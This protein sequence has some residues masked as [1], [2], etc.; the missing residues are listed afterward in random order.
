M[1]PWGQPRYN[2]HGVNPNRSYTSWWLNPRTNLMDVMKPPKKGVK[3]LKNGWV[4]TI[5]IISVFWN[6]HR[7]GEANYKTWGLSSIHP[8]VWGKYQPKNPREIPIQTMHY[9]TKEIHQNHRKSSYI[10]CL[11][12]I[13]PQDGL[14]F[15]DPCENPRWIATTRFPNFRRKW[16]SGGHRIEATSAVPGGLVD[17]EWIKTETNGIS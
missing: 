3:F 4:A 1:K 16:R 11:E 15:H 9:A 10:F 12:M 8:P 7:S 5:Q 6:R 14:A 2:V 17:S 13:P